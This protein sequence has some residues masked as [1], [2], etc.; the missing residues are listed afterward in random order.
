MHLW[1]VTLAIIIRVADLRRPVAG[2]V[3]GLRIKPCDS[4]CS[5]AIQGFM[6]VH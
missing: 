5:S 1:D 2:F 3:L 6:V 4:L